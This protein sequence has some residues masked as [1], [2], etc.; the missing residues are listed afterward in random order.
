MPNNVKTRIQFCKVTDSEFDEIVKRFTSDRYDDGTMAF[1]FE[2]IIPMPEY[3]FRGNLGASEKQLYGKNNWYDWSIK[4]WGTKW[5]AYDCN[6][7]YDGHAFEFSTAWCFAKPVIDKLSDLTK[8]QIL[9]M[10]ADENFGYNVG[11]LFYLGNGTVVDEDIEP[12]S[13]EAWAV[14]E[15]LWDV[16]RDDFAEVKW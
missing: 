5:N 12:N 14:V 9:A 11:I 13:D 2:K 6:I 15:S 4:N 8:T 10:Y 3:I 7:D 1:D 16:C